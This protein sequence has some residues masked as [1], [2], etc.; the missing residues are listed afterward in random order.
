MKPNLRRRLTAEFFGTLLLVATVVGS[1]IMAERL[2]NGN[3]ALALLANTI[4]TG[5]TLV[6][7]ILTFGP[8]SGAHFNPV[9]SVADALEGGLPLSETLVYVLAQIAGGIGGTLLAHIMFSLPYVSL[10]RHVRSGPS[11]F[12]SEVAAT[13]GL[14]CVI[15]GCS[16][17]RSN[18]V[19]FAVGSYI[20][21]AYWFTASTSFAN[22]AVTIARGLSDTFAGIRPIDVPLFIA[23]QFAG[24]IAATLLFRWL[25]PSLP[26]TAKDVLVPH[27]DK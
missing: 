17:S 1:G 5:A 6:A 22:P 15:W 2:A 3:V 20:T 24:G 13:F 25:V 12:V 11:Q 19:P 14:L 21:A 8:I 9:V 4:A 10:S 16:R 18:V 27:T 23:A 7:L 26:S